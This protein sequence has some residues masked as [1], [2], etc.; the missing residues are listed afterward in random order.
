[1]F[2][3]MGPGKPPPFRDTIFSARRWR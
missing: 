3:Y 2:A 1:V